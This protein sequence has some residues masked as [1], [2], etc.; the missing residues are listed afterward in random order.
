M[1]VLPAAFFLS[2][3]LVISGSFAVAMGKPM[4]KLGGLGLLLAGI[5]IAAVAMWISLGRPSE[6]FA[7]GENTDYDPRR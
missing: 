6:W 3:G 2:F 4:V 1:I 5:G 7:P